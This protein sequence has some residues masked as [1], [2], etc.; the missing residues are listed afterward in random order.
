M[1]VAA[2]NFL[3]ALCMLL[4]TLPAT[5]A[6]LLAKADIDECYNG[7]GASYEPGPYCE[8][9]ETPKANQAYLWGLTK[10]G[11]SMW[12]GTGSNILCLMRGLTFSLTNIG[13][14]SDENDLWVCEYTRGKYPREMID[15]WI[16]PNYGDFREPKVYKYDLYK[17]GIPQEPLSMAD[18]GSDIEERASK[19][20]DITETITDENALTLLENTFGL[21][22]AGSIG[23]LVFMAGPTGV[24]KGINIFAFNATTNELIDAKKISYYSN[25]RKWLVMNGNLYTTVENS[26]GGGSKILKWSGTMEDPIAFTI[27]GSIDGIGAEIAEHNK[28][29][30]VG[31]WP[32]GVNK[33]IAGIWMSPVV[34]SV[35]LTTADADDWQKVWTTDEYEPDPLIAHLYG[36][37]ALYSYNE[38]LYWGTMH[39]TSK[40]MFRVVVSYAIPPTGWSEAFQQSKRAISIFRTENFSSVELLYGDTQLPV[41]K[42]NFFGGTWSPQNNN[43]GVE[44]TY[45]TSGFGNPYNNYT[46]TMAVYN[47]KLYVGT[48]DNSILWENAELTDDNPEGADLWCFPSG[49][50]PAV[51]VTKNGFGNLTNYGI[52]TIYADQATGLY[53]GTANPGNIAQDDGNPI[54]GWELIRVK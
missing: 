36:V 29:I 40:N 10:S 42:R 8:P 20:E 21:R 17:N 5:G 51:A 15:R 2:I 6:E 16:P 25:I 1:K 35:G 18:R 19:I 13:E 28:R 27:V 24:G 38:K 31:T 30:Y 14:L 53:C 46:W 52:R 44:A 45:G 9:Y 43:M 7:T 39:V 37:G 3:V 54:G 22:S 11:N 23:N 48:M 41:Y 33:P 47:G 49:N 32:Q 12:I 34:Q 50:Q 26:R 4:L